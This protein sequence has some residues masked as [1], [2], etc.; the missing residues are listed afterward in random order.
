MHN[1]LLFAISVPILIVTVASLFLIFVLSF[2]RSSKNGK[3]IKILL[4]YDDYSLYD[5]TKLE[6][7]IL[8]AVADIGANIMV[9]VIP[10]PKNSYPQGDS[11]EVLSK[12]IK[13]TIKSEKATI[14]KRY[15]DQQIVDVAL[16][17]YN[18]QVNFETGQIK[19]EF[20]G[21]TFHMQ[22]SMLNG[23][24]SFLEE[25]IGKPID[26]FVP[27]FNA[28]DLN[29]VLSLESSGFKL[30]SAGGNGTVQKDSKLLFLPGTAYPNQLRATIESAR[31]RAI[32]D[33]LIV[34]KIHPYDFVESGAKETVTDLQTF[35]ED[36]K[37]TA[38]QP[39]VTITS[40][41]KLIDSGE[42]LSSDRLAA[43][44]QVKNNI[45]IKHQLIPKFLG[46]W[47]VYRLY[48]TQE[49]AKRLKSLQIFACVTFYA[50]LFVISSLTS[51][52]FIRIYNRGSLRLIKVVVISIGTA[53]G[54][55]IYYCY[56]KGS[57]YIKAAVS[58][59]ILSGFLL[60]SMLQLWKK[61]A[62]NESKRVK[63]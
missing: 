18:H 53:I 23:G 27:P 19:S 58:L 63:E 29:T 36:L 39:D 46:L 38:K 21:L 8:E 17:G 51:W 11:S 57:I 31:Q 52:F 13:S 50:A 22:K 41:K 56:M 20:A 47:P 5:G 54:I 49:I 40:Y 26:I 24:K 15:A 37:W 32:T 16:H 42:D 33:A 45:Y 60:G 1:K 10:F 6:E 62:L 14:L 9:S 48:Y 4:R 30:I 28:Y 61:T 2:Q 12:H 44:R 59:I 3:D 43:N 55:L 35:I 34:I 7:K 25:I